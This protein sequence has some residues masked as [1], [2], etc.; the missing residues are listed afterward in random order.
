MDRKYGIKSIKLGDYY[1]SL[2]ADCQKHLV[3]WQ[4]ADRD[5][6][7]RIQTFLVIIAK[8]KFKDFNCYCCVYPHDTS[9]EYTVF[10]DID[11]GNLYLLLT[12]IRDTGLYPNDSRRIHMLEEGLILLDAPQD[13][14]TILRQE[15]PC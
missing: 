13:V 6:Y 7:S 1:P 5:I 15:M 8:I 9:S 10:V 11:A 4:P 14:L 12:T 3:Q 2:L